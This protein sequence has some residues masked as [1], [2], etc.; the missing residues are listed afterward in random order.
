MFI[1]YYN[2][3]G[4]RFYSNPLPTQ[5]RG[6]QAACTLSYGDVASPS[7]VT[8]WL[9]FE[10]FPSL[11]SNTRDRVFFPCHNLTAGSTARQL[12]NSSKTIADLNRAGRI[13]T[14]VSFFGFTGARGTQTGIK[15]VASQDGNS[16]Y[17]LGIANNNYGLRFLPSRSADRTG[18]IYGSMFDNNTQGE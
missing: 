1:D 9:D 7:S 2:N 18:R 5:A 3:S 17:I 16:F 11:A 14:S 12:L 13:D 6:S 4:V 10:G 15:Q 8:Y